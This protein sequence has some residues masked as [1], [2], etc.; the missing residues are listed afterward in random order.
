MPAI[1]RLLSLFA[2]AGTKSAS[3]AESLYREAMAGFDNTKRQNTKGQDQAVLEKVTMRQLREAL[4]TLNGLSP[5][6]KPAIIDAC[7]HCI[8]HDGR[9]D[10]REYE[11]MRLVADQIDCPMP[12]LTA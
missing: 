7:G 8:T 4:T 5:L 9:V 3:D 10:V 6:L 2:R 1:Q 11:L 12:P